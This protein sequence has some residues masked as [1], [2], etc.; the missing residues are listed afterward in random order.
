MR[1]W[2]RTEVFLHRNVA[3]LLVA[4]LILQSGL[5]SWIAF[6]NSPVVDEIAHLPAGLSHWKFQ[7]FDLY[8]VN[9]PLVRS[10]AAIPVLFTE[11]KEDWDQ[12][13]SAPLARE[14]FNVGRAFVSANGFR[15]FH[16]VSLAR[17]ACIPFSWLGTL[18]CYRWAR[19]FS[20]RIAGLFAAALW[21]VCPNMLAH[22][23]LITPDAGASALGL[24]AA[25]C[26]W[27]WLQSPTW[28]GALFAG[29]TLGLA[30]LTKTTWL[31]LFAIWPLVFLIST[32][33]SSRLVRTSPKLASVPLVSHADKSFIRRSSLQLVTMLL[34]A[35]YTLNVGY[36]F[37]GTMKPLGSFQF[38]CS[39]LSGN[40]RDADGNRQPGNLFAGTWLHSIPV[41]FPSSFVG[42]IDL[43]KLDFEVGQPSYL[44]G[45]WRNHGWWYYYLYAM[46]V[47]VP[48][49]TILI[50][51]MSVI[52]AI[53]HLRSTRRF[54][55]GLL[56]LILPPLCI[57]ILV[58]QQTGLNKH[59]RY[60]LPVL[61]FLFVAMSAV[62]GRFRPKRI[63]LYR[64]AIFALL[65][66]TSCSSL[67]TCPINLVY[68][69]E[70]AGGP[71]NGARHLLDSNLDWGQGLF[72]LK[73]WND[74]RNDKLPLYVSYS[75]MFD[76]ADIGIDCHAVSVVDAHP[77]KGW[78]AISLNR[79]YGQEIHPQYVQSHSPDT[80]LEHSIAVIHID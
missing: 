22:G 58:S 30:E 64:P 35:L 76:P 71:E 38:K 79:L 63:Q 1:Y 34:I 31:V 3:W 26:F 16:Y 11:C 40:A 28:L 15:Y 19:D 8:R 12:Y 51:A 41:P 77:K 43:Q 56:V 48:L 65:L 60:V 5:L 2:R 61:P 50:A 6:S 68:F 72:A 67:R 80:F 73:E 62:L 55:A 49:G 78:Y 37:E 66:W 53:R 54:N 32:L 69:N 27:K 10:I 20:G 4:L 7:R 52:M 18:I 36:L 47:K 39:T 74:A 42:G 59:F 14:E 24:L 57:M 23:A 29:I 17:M 46:A 75:G 9:P 44:R 21:V 70:L 13:Q 33:T 45:E 25:Y